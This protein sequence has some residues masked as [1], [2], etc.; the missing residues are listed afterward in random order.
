[1]SWI[2]VGMAA[3]AVSA[4]TNI[5][6]KSIIHHYVRTPVTLPLL[7]GIAQ[8]TLGLILMAI[9]RVP[10]EAPVEA[11]WWA[12]ASGVTFGLAAQFLMR[13]LFT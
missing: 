12:L 6:D 2:V 5:L 8:T 3:A 13:G 11:V 10:A 9:V 1:M 7:S 4:A